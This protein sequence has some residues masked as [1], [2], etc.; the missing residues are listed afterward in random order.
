[1]ICIGDLPAIPSAS[2]DCEPT[3]TNIF[4]PSRENATSRV[5]CP[6]PDQRSLTRIS[7]ARLEIAVAIRETQNRVGIADI[8]EL[9]VG[10]GRVK[11]NA[12]RPVEAARENRHL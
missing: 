6:P 11:G 8:D 5:E 10:S 7:A 3:D 9:R 4:L 12:E 1:M 2:L